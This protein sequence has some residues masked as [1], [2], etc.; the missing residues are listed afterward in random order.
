MIFR[1]INNFIDV[2]I[3]F[4]LGILLS[5]FFDRRYPEEYRKFANYM[6]NIFVNI[7]YNCVYFYSKCQ[8][9]FTKYI[10]TNPFYLK[11]IELFKTKDR[12]GLHYLFVKDNFHY[13]ID[14]DLPDLIIIGN[15]SKVPT[16]KKIVYDEKH[17][18]V[19]FEDLDFEESNIKFMLIEFKIGYKPYKINL[20]TDLY[21]YYI[22]GNKFTKDFF[23][24]Y[25]NEHLLSKYDQHETNKDEKYM[26]KII[27]HDVNSIEIDFT[28]KNESILLEKN[29]YKLTI[30]N[31]NE[32]KE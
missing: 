9:F 2:L 31:H 11:V 18:D 29:G 16:P 24:Y 30:T 25:I 14:V 8:I 27:D 26:L 32:E 4:S 22:I 7:S 19:D 23:I 21:N 5:D 28:D 6:T 3:G 13:D 12:Y 17:K 20:K 10:A 1:Y 15:L